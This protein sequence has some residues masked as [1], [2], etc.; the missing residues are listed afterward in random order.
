MIKILFEEFEQQN[1]ISSTMK[2]EGICKIN[3]DDYEVNAPFSIAINTED[4]SAKS[5]KFN[6][7]IQASFQFNFENTGNKTLPKELVNVSDTVEGIL[8]PVS[9]VSN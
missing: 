7:G 1:Y 8:F 4:A 2:G 5:V 3:I 6:N 9:Y